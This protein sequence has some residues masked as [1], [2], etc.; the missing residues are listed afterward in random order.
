[1]NLRALAGIG[2]L[3]ATVCGAALVALPREQARSQSCPPPAIQLAPNNGLRGSSFTVSVQFCFAGGVGV[4]WDDFETLL[5]SFNTNRGGMGSGT[6]TVP[7]DASFG[8]HQVIAAFGDDQASAPFTVQQPPS[9]TP[10]AT[11]TPTVTPIPS[12][13]PTPTRTPTPTPTASPTSTP[14]STPTGTP[15]ATPSQTAPAAATATHTPTLAP[16]APASTPSPPP[17][18]SGTP[19]DT[20]SPSATTGTPSASATPTFTPTATSTPTGAVVVGG[21]V[22]PPGEGHSSARFQP[23]LDRDDP[24][25]EVLAHVAQLPADIVMLQELS[26]KW[27]VLGTNFFLALLLAILFGTS[28]NYFDNVI[29]SRESA[30]GGWLRRF[31]GFVNRLRKVDIWSSRPQRVLAYALL[32]IVF[33]LYGLLYTIL[34]PG[35]LLSRHVLFIFVA[36][37]LSIGIVELADD[38]G[39]WAFARR[40]GAKAHLSLLPT[41]VATAGFAAVVTRA[42][43]IV[44]GFIVGVPGALE[45]EEGELDDRGEVKFALS[46]WLGVLGVGI[47][48][49]LASAL[50]PVLF[51]DGDALGR[52]SAAHL[53]DFLLVLY[54]TCIEI[55]LFEMLPMLNS[56]G[57]ALFRL[58]KPAWALAFA[59]LLFVACMTLFNPAGDWADDF[60]GVNVAAVLGVVAVLDVGLILIW[61]FGTPSPA[62]A[63][64]AE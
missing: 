37:A 18:A 1:V 17:T 56:G 26:L 24:H 45:V 7:Q 16:G 55:L 41:N 57:Q 47:T 36:L 9:P 3:V 25:G 54:F 19:T 52:L 30:L 31:R 11:R 28:Q 12:F 44:P 48:A 61:K 27:K 15:T 14:T 63:P 8:A 49:W 34:E 64:A 22:S 42:F 2:L 58:N 4:F 32:P 62:T 60:K 33:G 23:R 50:V 35:D 13:T 53:Q 39:K 21:V 6:F 10:T 40:Q 43:G 51:D 38:L 20:P 46:G 29:E 5:G 59:A